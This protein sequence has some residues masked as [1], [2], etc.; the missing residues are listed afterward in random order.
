[1]FG[2]PD[3]VEQHIPAT[4]PFV[5]VYYSLRYCVIFHSHYFFFLCGAMMT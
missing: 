1:M 5:Y 2:Q 4:V 3:G